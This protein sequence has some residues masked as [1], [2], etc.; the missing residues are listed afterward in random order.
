[1]D[2]WMDVREVERKIGNRDMPTRVV[3]FLLLGGLGIS[4]MTI[5]MDCCRVD[6]YPV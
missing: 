4:W 3:N 6:F 2:G 1:M 5:C